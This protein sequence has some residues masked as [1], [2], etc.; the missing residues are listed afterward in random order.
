VAADVMI[1][2][3]ELAGVFRDVARLLEPGGLFAFTV[4]LPTNEGQELQLLPSLRYAHSEAYV[5]RLAAD[6]GLQVDALRAALI[7]HEQGAPVPGLYVTL[8]ADR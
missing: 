3:G 4:E 5:R 8:R 7:R 6:A 1:Y 2:V